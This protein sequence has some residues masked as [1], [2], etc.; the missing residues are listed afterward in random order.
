MPLISAENVGL[1]RVTPLL[2]ADHIRSRLDNKLV[3]RVWVCFREVHVAG[4]NPKTRPG[5]RIG[6]ESLPG[7]AESGDRPDGDHEARYRRPK[8]TPPEDQRREEQHRRPEDENPSGT[9][10]EEG[11][12]RPEIPG[13]KTSPSNQDDGQRQPA[14]GFHRPT[15]ATSP[16]IL[17]DFGIE[18]Y[19]WTHRIA[20]KDVLRVC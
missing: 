17:W 14:G 20:P 6:A 2:D 19:R 10:Q 1:C 5:G 13:T 7:N 8:S 12:Q 3:Q 9:E 18:R 11:T 15:D 4:Q 16:T